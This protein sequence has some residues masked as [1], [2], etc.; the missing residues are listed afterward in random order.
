MN[1]IKKDGGQQDKVDE[2]EKHGVKEIRFSGESDQL[3]DRVKD[4][5]QLSLKLFTF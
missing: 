3:K 4:F 1:Q 5:L 2:D